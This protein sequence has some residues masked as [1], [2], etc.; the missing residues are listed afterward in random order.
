MKI[1]D[2]AIFLHRIPYSESSLIVTLYTK[3]NGIQKMLFQGG[4]KKA[5]VLF[6]LAIGEITYYNRPESTLG[7]LTAFESVQALQSITT[8]PFKSTIV[9]FIAE[10]IQNCLRT[11]EKEES[12]FLFLVSMIEAL[13]AS[14]E[15]ANFPVQFLIDFSEHLGIQPH[16]EE[17][18]GRYF[19]LN[20]GI[21]GHQYSRGD[22]L[23]E[24]P[25]VAAI[26]QQLTTGTLQLNA[27]VRKE[28]L[29]VILQYY[30]MHIPQFKDLK[31]LEIVREI[32]S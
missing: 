15:I 10:V 12:I 17:E 26:Q 20:E 29:A 1:V 2:K 31:T 18:N 8:N 23:I 21:I 11:E 9:F 6:P 22:I 4:K 14:T 25:V 30:K 24:G 3:S 5:A 19:N 13:E 27:F 28:L 7:K 32:L 16:I